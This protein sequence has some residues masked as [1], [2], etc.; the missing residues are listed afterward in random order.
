[1]KYSSKKDIFFFIIIW[2]SILLL[3]MINFMNHKTVNESLISFIIT[4]IINIFFLWLWFGTN[5]TI[6]NSFLKIKYGPFR[7]K[8]DIKKIRSIR[9]TKSIF[10]A[11]AL[12]TQRL[13]LMYNKYE[14]VDI[15]PKNE[16]EFLHKLLK[17]NPKIQLKG[18]LRITDEPNET[19]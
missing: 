8:V 15:A 18:N 4:L 13:Q 19:F 7:S 16:S 10:T 14:V 11:P 2:G 1:M 6:K 17:I 3:F 5:Y 9:R 12:A